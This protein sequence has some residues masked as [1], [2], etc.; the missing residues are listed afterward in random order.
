MTD[1]DDLLHEAVELRDRVIGPRPAIGCRWPIDDCFCEP[2]YENCNY[3][4]R[5]PGKRALAAS[6]PQP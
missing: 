1:L 2:P 4:R 6:E 5:N 3:E